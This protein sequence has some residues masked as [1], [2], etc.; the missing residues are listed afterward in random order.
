MNDEQKQNDNEYEDAFNQ[1]EDTT[2]GDETTQSHN[3]ETLR[4]GLHKRIWIS[5]VIASAFFSAISAFLDTE[6]P[7]EV[8]IGQFFIFLAVWVLL[9][10]IF[11]RKTFKQL[12]DD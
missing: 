11:L 9:H 12:K 4:R 1:Q 3:K 5:G 7:L 2:E 8:T 10:Y 6:V